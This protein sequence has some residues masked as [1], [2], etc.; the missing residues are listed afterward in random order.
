[1]KQ[2]EPEVPL[3]G[4][5]HSQAVRLGRTV[6]RATHPWS[7]SV[8]ELLQHLEQE[9]FSGA[10]R[11]LGI[12]ERG[13]EVVTYVEGS[14]GVN[15]PDADAGPVQAVDHWVWRDDVLVHLGLLVRKYHDAAATF[16]LAGREWQLEA[17]HPVETI[18]HNDL[19]PSNVVFRAG[20]P[21]ALIDWEAAA[22]GPR[23][24]DLGFAAWRW[25]P[26]W[27]EERCRAA[28]LPTGT[29]EQGAPAQLAARRLWPRAESSLRADSGHS[30]AAIPGPPLRARSCR[31]GVGGSPAPPWSSQ[32]SRR[33]DRMGG[34]P[35]SRAGRVIASWTSVALPDCCSAIGQRNQRA[36][37]ARLAGAPGQRRVTAVVGGTGGAGPRW[38]SGAR[39]GARGRGGRRPEG[40]ACRRRR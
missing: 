13:R 12:D 7:S 5:S 8:F 39:Q 20:V 1:M 30:D 26:F 6:R 40:R 11:A 37:V 35:R 3:D 24:W 28:G 25:V 23:A 17:R 21:A 14:A 2:A 29:A 34:A 36:V 15:L 22:P 16:P 9:G 32:R 27:P 31:L 10:P 4:G 18:C 19:A 38:R 33:R